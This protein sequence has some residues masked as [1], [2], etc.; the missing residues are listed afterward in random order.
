MSATLMPTEEASVFDCVCHE[1]KQVVTRKV[2]PMLLT[3]EN[4]KA[5]WDKAQGF[6]T[7]FG[8]TL[9]GDFQKFAE[10]LISRDDHDNL[11]ANG[12]FWRVDDFVG[13]FYM[14]DIKVY[15]AKIHYTFLDRTH[16]GRQNITR[17]MIKF[18]FEKYGFRR[19]TA[20]IPCFANG[21]F[22]FVKQ[23]GLKQEGRKRMAALFDNE[24]FDVNCYGVLREEADSWE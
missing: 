9:G 22:E 17:K 7:L 21:T 1:R 5:F 13:V 12:L 16:W 11:S 10:M 24:W 3:P 15:D 8:D 2:Y 18:V 20:E 19:L 4:I 14:T 6:R 23:V